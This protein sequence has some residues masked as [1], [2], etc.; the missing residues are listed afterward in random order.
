MVRSALGVWM[1]G[2][3]V[4][5][6]KVSRA[7]HS[8]TYDS[9]WLESPRARSL[10]L[11]LPITASREIRGPVVAH[12][13]DNLLPDNDQIRARLARRFDT[14]SSDALPLLEA[15]GRDCV[16]AVQLLPE[17][18]EPQGWNRIQSQVLDD[19]QIVDILRA[20]PT[21][22]V[23]DDGD[24]DLFRIS[25]AGAQEKTAFLKVKGQWCRPHGA[26]PT[27]HIFKLPLGT[28][29]GSRQVDLST[30]VQNEWL[31]AQL[32]EEPG[33]P[34][35]QCT[36]ETFAD[37]SVLVVERFDREWMDG[38]RWIA[39]LPQEDFCQALG[40][41]PEKKYEQHGGPGMKACLQLLHGS[42]DPQDLRLFQLTQLAFWLLGAT[43]G[44]AKNFSI[45][46]Q[47]GDSYVTTPLYDILSMW[48]YVG[49]GPHQFRR[50]KIALAM[51]MRSK[52]AHYAIDQ[53]QVR[54]W[55]QLAMTNGGPEVW[56]AMQE[57]VERAP[58][59]LGAVQG[60]LPRGFN[61]RL[62][63]A[64]AGGMTAQVEKFRQGMGQV[65]VV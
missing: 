43:D 33:L 16:G 46:L 11:S 19:G 42:A 27:T 3:Y 1:N 49:D 18:H 58:V 6:W 20:V 32:A 60:R 41:P 45:F 10:S 37:Q 26:T 24:D 65:R 61:E 31:C 34:V 40:V 5:V 9:A 53:I 36:M 56:T 51:A 64:I 15:I 39:R 13:F 48:P 57:L 23:V 44:H 8:F 52:N 7:A 2:E 30:S 47:P 54:H 22:G 4:G 25:I 63:E 59:A 38:G 55:H 14:V 35:A 62:W 28:V 29:G 50:K 21:L 12:Y 17:G